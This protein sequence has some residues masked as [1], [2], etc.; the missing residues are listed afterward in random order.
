M[1]DFAARLRDRVM[2]AVPVRQWVLTVPYEL[3]A[4]LAFDPSL[5]NLGP[6]LMA[7]VSSWLRRRARGL[8]LRGT[9]KTGAV[10]VVQRF[11][12]ALDL[13]P[14]FHALVLDCV[15]S[16]PGGKKP[17]FHLTP[18]PR[19]E[20]VARVAAAVFRRVERKLKD[21]NPSQAQ[22]R[23]DKGAPLLLALAEASARGVVGTGPRKGAASSASVGLPPIWMSS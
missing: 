9:L 2:P 14:H 19:D 22:R 8:G 17:V 6:E 12:S 16:F 23:F 18:S 1:C 3:R 4:K 20:D 10:T 7:A 15:Y 11:N 5:T 21:R 13:S